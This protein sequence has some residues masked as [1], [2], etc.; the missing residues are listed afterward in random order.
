M[1][2]YIF[3]GGGCQKRERAACGEGMEPLTLA[4]Q[5]GKMD[6]NLKPGTETHMTTYKQRTLNFL[7]EEWGTF[8]ER[9]QRLPADEGARRVKAQGYESLRDLLAH[10]LA[11]WEEGFP[12][13]QAIAENRNFERKKYDFDVF[14]AEAVKKYG[15]WNEAEFLARFESCRRD[16]EAGLRS[17]EDAVF[18]NRR[19]RGWLNAVVISHAREHHM[20]PGR[21]LPLDTLENEWG[22]YIERFHALAPDQQ[23]EFLSKQGFETFHDLLAHIIGWM[24]ETLR[25]IN[26][27]LEGSGRVWENRDTDA[28][29]AE[30]IARFHNWSDAD[31]FAHFE[32]MRKAALD[33]V[34]DLPDD[35][36]SNKDIEEWLAADVVG[37]FDD[38]AL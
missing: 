35:A 29:N 22:G 14:N 8:I 13:I 15:T 3:R 9:F 24:E 4:Q 25:G 28:V 21:F 31:L 38:H 20:L 5:P 1:R 23:A 37:H 18:E 26:E 32:N 27:T 10:V 17:M 11:W 16:M 34:M 36:F 33:A 12:I 2:K 6:C 19:V 7:R 30:W